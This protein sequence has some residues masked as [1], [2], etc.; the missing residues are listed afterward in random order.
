MPRVFWEVMNSGPLRRNA[1]AR[2]PEGIRFED[3]EVPAQ[4]RDGVTSGRPEFLHPGRAEPREIIPGV[5][6]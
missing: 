1:G 4:G 2:A 5:V 6:G 3:C